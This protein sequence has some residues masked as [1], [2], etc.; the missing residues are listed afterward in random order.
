[1]NSHNF[2]IPLM[3]AIFLV[4][5][6]LGAT[7]TI[8]RLRSRRVQQVSG[9]F[10]AAPHRSS[11][12]FRLANALLAWITVTAVVAAF[13]IVAVGQVLGLW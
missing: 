3:A 6:L 12:R 11:I 10:P 7:F 8:F 2:L 13:A 9:P 5:N 1:M 4:I